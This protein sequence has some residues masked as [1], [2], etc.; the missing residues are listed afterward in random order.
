[1][2]GA[3][4]FHHQ[5]Q[6][7]DHHL[8]G[9]PADDGQVVADVHDRHAEFLLQ[10][11]EQ[12]DDLRLNGHIERGSRFVRDQQ[13]GITGQRHCN[14]GPLTHP[15]AKL[16]GIGVDTL[17]GARNTDAAQNLNRPLA[18]FLLTDVRN[19]EQNRLH[20]LVADGMHWAKGGHRFLEDNADL[21]A[22]NRPVIIAPYWQISEN[23]TTA[24]H[25]SFGQ[26]HGNTAAF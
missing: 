7:H 16:V 4:V 26:V 19:M 15:A 2:V 20:N 8:I 10:I 5:A 23:N 22:A 13:L 14:H 6:V 24:A 3:G 17:F 12:F 1:M 21:F 18:G 25:A 11:L 9:H